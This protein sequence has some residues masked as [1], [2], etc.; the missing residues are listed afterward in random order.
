MRPKYYKEN[1]SGEKP[2]SYMCE[3][4]E[5]SK[6]KKC[7]C[8]NVNG[9]V[10]DKMVCDALLNYENDDSVFAGYVKQISD[11]G[12]KTDSING[13]IKIQKDLISKKKKN[14]SAI[15]DM[16]VSDNSPTFDYINDKITQLHN[17]I[18]TANN[19]IKR[20][21]R[22]RMSGETLSDAINNTE[23]MLRKF[24][25][26]FDSMSVENK[27]AFIRK[28]VSKVEWDG[29]NISVFLLDR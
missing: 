25:S 15:L 21:E 17:E 9:R 3:L 28:C 12:N 22:L 4:K 1:K 20:L 2:F 10:V 14:I 18:E 8:Q 23:E 19:E 27:R 29:E 16:A 26:G 7:S 11:I 24:K 13:L 5:T 6:K